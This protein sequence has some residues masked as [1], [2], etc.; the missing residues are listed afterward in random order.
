[1]DFFNLLT[2]VGGLALFLYGMN[3]MG[4]GLTKLSGGRME[5]LLERLTSNRLM[6]VLLGTVVTGVIQSSSATTVMV[7]GFVNSGIMKLSQTIGIIMGANIGT[8]VT[9]WL[10]SLTGIESSNVFLR[11]LK[12]SSF[13]PVLAVI[14]IALIMFAKSEKKKDIGNIMVGFAVLMFG[15]ETMSGAVAPLAKVKEFTDIL[16]MFSNPLLGMLAGLTLTAVIQSSSASV[17]ILQ[18]LCLTGTVSF[19]T[20]LPIILGQNIGTCITA[21]LSSIGTSKNAKRAAAVHLYFNIIGTFLFAIIFYS[22]NYFVSFKFLG[23]VASPAGIAIIHSSFNIGAT[24]VLFPFA[25][26]LEKL[27]ILTIRDKDSDNDAV[28][29]GDFALLDERFLN[30]P[31]FA[32]EEC[33]K[34]AVS[35][36]CQAKEAINLSID[37]I[38]GYDK[39]KAAQVI[40]L[41]EVVDRYEDELGSYLVKLSCKNLSQK[42]SVT[43]SILLHCIGDF[44][45]ISDHAVNLQEAAYEMKR[46]KLEFSKKAVEELA[47][48]SKGV[49]DIVNI[50]VRAFETGDLK[51]ARQIEPLE[52]VID[53]LNLE[54]KQRHIKRLRNGK[55]TIELGF[56]LSDIS[57]NFER[58]ADHCSNIGVCILQIGEDNFDMHEYL[59][60]MK[61]ESN[62]DFKRQYMMMKSKYELPGKQ[63]TGG[64]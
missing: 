59:D 52:Q 62:Q 23:E 63:N 3:I 25:K 39:K 8:T 41:E 42:D 54:E 44:E 17:G 9:S 28:K 57:T 32:I 53:Y 5:R 50:S 26:G 46:K 48:F 16:T 43:L 13:S 14:G 22:I 20:A 45:R 33:R 38:N 2:M 51:L 47:V 4:D 21:I 29:K 24:L 30:K 58:V 12:P 61:D 36:A 35:M 27:A 37:L 10:L 34:V 56:I 1:M 55:C 11:L 49:K 19:G 6:A 40:A 31:G 7:V 18:A 15:M 64:K 60:I